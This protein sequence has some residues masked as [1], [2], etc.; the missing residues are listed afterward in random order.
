V[1]EPLHPLNPPGPPRW[2]EVALLF[3]PLYT[4]WRMLVHFETVERVAAR[5]EP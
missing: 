5:S 2:W 3:C 4:A 1:T